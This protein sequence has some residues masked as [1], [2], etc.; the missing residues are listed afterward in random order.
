MAAGLEIAA[1]TGR[2]LPHHRD[3]IQLTGIELSP[4]M[5]EIAK[6]REEPQTYLPSGIAAPRANCERRGSQDSNLDP[7]GTV[8]FAPTACT[9]PAEV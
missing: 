1:G 5:L 9:E 2:N 3:D 8:P 7:K 6:Q 4:Q